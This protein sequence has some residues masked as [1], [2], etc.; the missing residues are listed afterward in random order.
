MPD[1]L[2][3]LFSLPFPQPALAISVKDGS[4]VHGYEPSPA[5]L[6]GGIAATIRMPIRKRCP[7]MSIFLSTAHE[8]VNQHPRYPPGEQ[9]AH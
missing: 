8:I 1:V 3:R 5:W 7:T 4:E 2:N 6:T 9:Y